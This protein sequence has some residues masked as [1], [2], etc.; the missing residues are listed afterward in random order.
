M[1]LHGY[2]KTII[3][4]KTF[5]P[6]EFDG[7]HRKTI[8][9][10]KRPAVGI[11]QSNKHVPIPYVSADI[12]SHGPTTGTSIS[13]SSS[14]K[15]KTKLDDNGSVRADEIP[16]G[17]TDPDDDYLWREGIENSS[18]AVIQ[19]SRR[20]QT[21]MRALITISPGHMLQGMKT[22]MS[23]TLISRYDQH[24]SNRRNRIAF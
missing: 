5:V 15:G 12:A 13:V 14:M 17:S 4:V 10:M 7:N 6:C 19:G 3:D 11:A 9:T 8:R 2:L 16:H 20:M 1:Y 21:F 23:L 24:R 22:T 18:C